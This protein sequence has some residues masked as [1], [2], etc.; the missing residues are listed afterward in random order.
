[1]REDGDRELLDVVRRDVIAA[2]QRREG[3]AR[4][5]QTQRRP[6]S[7]AE[8]QGLVPPQR[9]NWK[10]IVIVQH[11]GRGEKLETIAK[12]FGMSEEM[13]NA[14]LKN[15]FKAFHVKSLKGLLTKGKVVRI[16]HES[17]FVK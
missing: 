10:Q 17:T 16:I 11:L 9:L 7:G 2:A 4:F 15:L 6:R 13:F 14:Y 3:P 12:N 1:M 5:Q 8:L